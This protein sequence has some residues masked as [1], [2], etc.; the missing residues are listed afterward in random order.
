MSWLNE[1]KR[2]FVKVSE[3]QELFSVS[4]SYVYELINCGALEAIKINGKALRVSIASVKKMRE[5]SKFDSA[6]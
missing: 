3:V 4:R 6:Q 1:T 5:E 2:E